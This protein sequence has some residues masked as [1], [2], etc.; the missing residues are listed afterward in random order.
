MQARTVRRWCE[1]AGTAPADAIVTADWAS[2]GSMEPDQSHRQAMLAWFS[3]RPEIPAGDVLPW[4][5][6]QTRTLL[7]E[8][9][10][11]RD[12]REW[13][14]RREAE[15]RAADLVTRERVR[16]AA[17]WAARG[18]PAAEAW[19]RATDGPPEIDAKSD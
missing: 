15:D 11:L 13:R 4:A 19:A 1:R 8:H 16:D 14:V 17:L 5:Q 18:V 3:G 6:V 12:L 7:A 10:S 9:G 2:L